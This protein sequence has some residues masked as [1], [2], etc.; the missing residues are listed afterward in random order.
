MSVI[1]V[2]DRG[3]RSIAE[4]SGALSCL[5]FLSPLAVSM[6]GSQSCR[7]GEVGLPQSRLLFLITLATVWLVIHY[8]IGT[9]RSSIP[10]SA[11]TNCPHTASTP[12]STQTLP[13]LLSTRKLRFQ[14]L[15]DLFSERPI[16]RTPDPSNT[17][18]FCHHVYQLSHHKL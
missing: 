9:Y 6:A 3:A 10:Q 16:F 17:P 2:L 14:V 15:K 7:R 4:V 1:C 13:S 12:N 5:V 18:T 11:S 8:K